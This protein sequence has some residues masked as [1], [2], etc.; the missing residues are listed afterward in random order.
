MTG[1][2]ITNNKGVAR[3]E[4]ASEV[5]RARDSFEPLFTDRKEDREKAL[6]I[7]AGSHGHMIRI[8]GSLPGEAVVKEASKT[9]LKTLATI[10][11]GPIFIGSSE[12]RDARDSGQG[13]LSI[14][15]IAKRLQALSY[16]S[17]RY[18]A[19][20]PVFGT[21]PINGRSSLEARHI[22]GDPLVDVAVAKG[23]QRAL[24][25]PGDTEYLWNQEARGMT[26]FAAEALKRNGAHLSV[27]FVGGGRA[28][29][30]EF[31]LMRGLAEQFP[32]RVSFGGFS[33]SGG[34]TDRLIRKGALTGIATKS[35][36]LGA[37]LRR[38]RLEAGGQDSLE[39]EIE[40]VR[41]LR[42]VID[43]ILN[44]SGA[45]T[46]TPESREFG[47]RYR[48]VSRALGELSEILDYWRAGASS[49]HHSE[50]G[51]RASIL[52]HKVKM[53]GEREH[54]RGESGFIGSHDEYAL[55]RATTRTKLF[56][57]ACASKLP[58]MDATSSVMD[59]VNAVRPF[60]D[61]EAGRIID[62]DSGR[63]LV[64]S[65]REVLTLGIGRGNNQPSVMSAMSLFGESGS[66]AHS[67]FE[68]PFTQ[69]LLGQYPDAVPG[70]NSLKHGGLLQYFNERGVMIAHEELLSVSARRPDYT[71]LPTTDR[72]VEAL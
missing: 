46:I 39:Q 24:V 35:A 50:E 38:A 66:L 72:W 32:G 11:T 20:A 70:W 23:L 56:F 33:G 36:S 25:F 57:S 69:R 16:T 10:P 43:Q 34:I 67:V 9:F 44:G 31:D 4:P 13:I 41:A 55:G 19:I 53:F 47:A 61:I 37:H 51:L 58:D 6:T 27:I 15:G 21:I 64:L 18:G 26:S 42:P 48:E 28:A 8:V 22:S 63:Y 5:S 7:C 59:V 49:G 1:A 71:A 2:A 12:S 40:N 68:A 60:T 3:G 54:P 65:N 45:V 52:R 29:E 17:Q 14:P 30:L 62:G